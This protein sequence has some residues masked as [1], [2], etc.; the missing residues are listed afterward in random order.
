MSYLEVPKETTRRNN[1][2][3]DTNS[4]INRKSNPLVC[5]DILTA[6]NTIKISSDKPPVDFTCQPIHLTPAELLIVFNNVKV[7]NPNNEY[8]E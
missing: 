5:E 1:T 3:V 6:L 8:P 4:P 2:P 7:Y